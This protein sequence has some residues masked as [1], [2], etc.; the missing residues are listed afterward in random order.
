YLVMKHVPYVNA[1]GQICYGAFASSLN[2]AGDKTKPPGDH[3]IVFVG[4][5]PYKADGQPI[6]THSSI[7][8][9]VAEGL[10]A[11]LKFS[12]KPPGGYR[13]YYHQMTVYA[14]I[15]SGPAQAID[16]EANPR[17]FREADEDEDNVF[18]YADTATSRAG[19]T[20]VAEKLRQERIA[21]IGL[22]GTGSYVLDFVSKSPVTEIRTYDADAMETH[23]AFRSPGA[24]SIDQLREQPSKVDH[25]RESYA[26]MHRNILAHPVMLDESNMTLLDGVTFAFICIDSGT[27]KKAIIKKLESIGADFVDCGMGVELVDDA[28]TGIVR[29]TASTPDHRDHVHDGR[30]SFAGGGN[31]DV[32]SSNIQIAELNG[33]NAALAVIKWK[34]IRGFYHDAIGEMHSLYTI[35]END[36]INNDTKSS[37]VNW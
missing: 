33:L 37:E 30:V 29:T 9:K 12:R 4:E 27:A 3:T 25:H 15:F 23:N 14:G 18:N 20:A 31:E 6:K 32:Y 21:I 11:S 1:E 22:G 19:T 7:T 28:L 17:V 26:N 35:D 36:V 13:D 8:A 24:M 34:K 16:P 5:L 2:L 10:V